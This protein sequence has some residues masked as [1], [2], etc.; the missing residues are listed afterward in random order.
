[1]VGALNALTLGGVAG[2]K[3]RGG[4]QYMTRQQEGWGRNRRPGAGG[5][6]AWRAGGRGGAGQE[7]RGQGSNALAVWMVQGPGPRSRGQPCIDW[8]G[9]RGDGAAR[10]LQA[11]GVEVDC[12]VKV[13]SSGMLLNTNDHFMHPDSSLNEEG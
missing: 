13:L 11:V 9:W 5:S 7:P 6:M 8:A 12:P 4:E 3:G 10:V 1:M 2:T